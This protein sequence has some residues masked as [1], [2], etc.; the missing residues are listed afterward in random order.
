MLSIETRLHAS[1]VLTVSPG[2]CEHVY[3]VLQRAL[4]LYT[5]KIRWKSGTCRQKNAIRPKCM[6]AQQRICTQNRG[7]LYTTSGFLITEKL[8]SRE[9][10]RERQRQRERDRERQRER[11]RERQRETETDR[12]R[13]TE[14]E[15]QRQ[16]DRETETEIQRQTQRQRYRDRET[17]RQTDR[18]RQRKTEIK[19]KNV[20]K[21]VC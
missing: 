12:E 15:R 2:P 19:E 10:E 14:T 8:H 5:L 13:D 7:K 16:K 9:R 1:V 3:D 18:Q 17:D 21:Q 20:C 6:V 11:D 4:G